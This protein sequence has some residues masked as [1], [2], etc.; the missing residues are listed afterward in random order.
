MVV[1]RIVVVAMRPKVRGS[2]VELDVTNAN[3]AIGHP[4]ASVAEVGTCATTAQ[5]GVEHL[6]VSALK[7][8]ERFGWEPLATPKPRQHG[9]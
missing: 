8:D 4:D 7:C 2:D 9:F 3:E 1:A 6:D 5:P